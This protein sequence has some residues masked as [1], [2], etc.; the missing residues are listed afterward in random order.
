MIACSNIRIY[1]F[2]A[3]IQGSTQSQY[4]SY[5]FQTPLDVVVAFNDT[6]FVRYKVTVD[7][8]GCD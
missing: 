6:A 8:I 3:Y 7:T 5:L 2:Q 4:F 1:P